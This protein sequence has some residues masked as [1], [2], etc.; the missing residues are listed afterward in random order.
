MTILCKC[1]TKNYRQGIVF[2]FVR[3]HYHCYRKDFFINYINCVFLRIVLVSLNI[4]I[5]IFTFIFHVIEIR[6]RSLMSFMSNK[7]YVAARA[8][9]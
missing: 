9:H 3:L 4:K 2:F 8:P 7:N 1:I 5:R 6:S